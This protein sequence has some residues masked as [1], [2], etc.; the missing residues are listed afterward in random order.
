MK[1]KITGF[2]RG[3]AIV[4]LIAGA[5]CVLISLLYGVSGAATKEMITDD[6]STLML[7]FCPPSLTFMAIDNDHRLIIYVI[8]CIE[9][10]VLN[11]L[12]YAAIGALLQK[13]FKKP[14]QQ[15]S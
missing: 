14:A 1:L 4:G 12:L 9:V 3:F 13:F 5:I 6:L 10:M 2:T 8:A 7:V 15:Q 11:T